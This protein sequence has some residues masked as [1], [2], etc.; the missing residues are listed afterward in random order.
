MVLDIVLHVSDCLELYVSS[1]SM[2]DVRISIT[3]TLPH[4]LYKAM[5]VP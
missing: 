1:L 4:A 2:I 3:C 5:I